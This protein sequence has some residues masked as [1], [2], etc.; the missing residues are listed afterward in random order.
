[1]KTRGM[2]IF[3]LFL[4]LCL[5]EDVRSLIPPVVEASDIKV[6]CGTQTGM[7]EPLMIGP[8]T[9]VINV[10]D[11]PDVRNYTV[12]AFSS[13]NPPCE[14][15]GLLD[16]ST[17]NPGTFF[18]RWYAYTWSAQT[19]GIGSLGPCGMERKNASTIQIKIEVVE[20]TCTL[21]T[22]EEKAFN[23]S[24]IQMK[25]VVVEGTLLTDKDKAFV[26]ECVYNPAGTGPIS[27][28]NID[29]DIVPPDGDVSA[30]GTP[31]QLDRTYGLTL[32][33]STTANPVSNPVN[34][35][36]HV[37][38]RVLASGDDDGTNGAVGDENG[39][40]VVSCTAKNDDGSKQVV[41]INEYCRDLT[42]EI[43]WVPISP[44]PTDQVG[45]TS[46]YLQSFSPPFEMFA[47][48]GGSRR[49]LVTFTCDV[50]VCRTQ[51]NCDG[52]NCPLKRR[53]R[54]LLNS[55]RGPKYS[56]VGDGHIQL[57]ALV[58]VQ[59]VDPTSGNSGAEKCSRISGKQFWI[60][61]FLII[62]HHD[63]PN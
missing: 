6:T 4:L 36:T 50:D 18:N 24:T 40:R 17:Q 11:L 34:I 5:L 38:L 44:V 2:N 23:A 27:T 49:N 20:G 61:S 10:Q 54:E 14:F 35:G 26:I 62:M 32:I 48:T 13:D 31:N 45:F 43:K 46:K 57:T 21:L 59:Y 7:S 42:S 39:V 58:M 41:I 28:V 29:N 22:D 52:D 47:I 8:V 30:T 15:S 12:Y 9:I 56:N 53:K 33:Y 37:Q 3:S 60:L 55:I 19:L 1:M 63:S 51:D 25:I 16:N